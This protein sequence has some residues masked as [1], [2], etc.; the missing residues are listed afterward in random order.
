MRSSGVRTRPTRKRRLEA[1]GRLAALAGDTAGS[2]RA[3]RHVLALSDGGEAP[4]PRVQE[5]RAAL[6]RLER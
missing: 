1:L 3:Y 6:T 2:V 4:G 5:V